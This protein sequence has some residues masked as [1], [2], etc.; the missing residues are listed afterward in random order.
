MTKISFKGVETEFTPIP[1]GSYDAV[2]KK[3]EILIGKTSGQP[4]VKCE[5]AVKNEEYA[6][7]KLWLNR[8]LQPQSLWAIKKDLITMGIDTDRLEDEDADIEEILS[9]A[10][11]AQV[12][13]KVRVKEYQG[14]FSNE[15]LA[16]D[17]PQGYAF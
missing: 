16:V 14:K 7:R 9:D 4:Y 1:E 13:L 2:L 17:D 11:G 5:Y 15:I 10:I 3:A 8:S 6:G 12:T